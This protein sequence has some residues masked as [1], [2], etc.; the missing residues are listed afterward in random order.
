M[1]KTIILLAA[2]TIGSAGH[3]QFQVNPQ[4]GLTYQNLTDPDLGYEYKGAI[5]WQV[6]ADFR[7][8]DRLFFQPGV[9]FGRNTTAIRFSGMDSTIIEDNL[10]RTNLKLRAMAGYRIVDSYQ[11]D[12]RFMVGPSYDVL[13]SVDDKD[14]DITWNKGDFN[15]GSFNIDAGLGFDMGLFTLE[16]GVSFGLSRVFSDNPEVQDI[17]S[18]YLTYGLTI[19]VNFGDDD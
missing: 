12:L 11:F 15:A 7:I 4:L 17:S 19:G 2:L 5:G 18:K 10:I 8:G 14:G 9:F 1:K 13:L 3:A 16:P 6:G